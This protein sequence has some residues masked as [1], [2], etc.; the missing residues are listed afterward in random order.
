MD[1]ERAADTTAMPPEGSWWAYGL[2]PEER[3]R[4]PGPPTSRT[5]AGTPA[6]AGR[7]PRSRGAVDD[8]AALSADGGPK[9]VA[10]DGTAI[11]S[12]GGT[13]DGRAGH[14]DGA[15]D[16]RLGGARADGTAALSADGGPKPA[17]PDGPAPVAARLTDPLTESAADLAARTAR[18]D[19][20]AWT[21]RAVA[22]APEQEPAVPGEVEWETGF[23]LICAPFAEEAAERFARS[24]A[25]SGLP[26]DAAA[27]RAAFTE[28]LTGRLV[29]TAARCLVAELHTARE[30]GRLDGGSAH[31]RFASFVRQTARRRGLWELLTRYPVL[32]RLLAQT[33]RHALDAWTELLR[34][35]A[36]DREAIVRTLL[37]GTDPG[38]L[39]EVAVRGDVHRRGRAVAVLTFAD[40]GRI[41]YKPRSLAT[42]RHFN[43]VLEWLDARLPEAGLRTLRLLDRATHGWVEHVAAAPCRSTAHVDRFYRRLGTLMAVLHALDATDIHCENLIACA[44]QP[45]LVDLETLFHPSD[46]GAVGDDPAQRALSASVL[47]IALLPTL[48]FGRSGG[49]DVSALGGGHQG[50]LPLDAPH[51]AAPGTDRMHL[52]YRPAR[53]PGADNRPR[54]GEAEVDP[55]RFAEA[56]LD[57]FRAGYDTIT[58]HRAEF[59]APDG[60]VRAFVSDEARVVARPTRFYTTLLD[61]LTHPDV[62]AD[63]LDR[64]RAFDLLRTFPVR[65]DLDQRVVRHEVTDLWAG[66]VPLFTHRVGG[67]D[68]TAAGQVLPR[69]FAVPAVDRVLAK[70][71]AMG[72]VDRYDQEWIIRAAVA[73]GAGTGAHPC[74]ADGPTG[75]GRGGVGPSGPGTA[76][77]EQCLAAARHIADR[78]IAGGF[79]DERR[80]NWLGL[81]RAD[82]R[83]WAV[84]PLG[85]GFAH[86]YTG[87]AVF[88]AQLA[89]LGSVPRYADAARR[90]V[91]PVPRLLEELSGQPADL[92][93]VGCG[94][95][96]GLGG[97]AYALTHLA[98]LLRDDEVAAWVEPAVELAAEAAARTTALTVADGLAGGV[99]TMLAVHEHTG[100]PAAARCAALCAE[101]LSSLMSRPAGATSRLPAGFA[102]GLHGV[103]WALTR[104]A[105]A[106]GAPV[107]TG[108]VE[109]L[110]AQPATGSDH[111]WRGGLSGIGF[112]LA[113]IPHGAHRGTGPALDRAVSDAVRGG[114]LPDH[115]L[116]RGEL[117]RLELLTLAAGLGHDAALTHLAHRTGA[118]LADLTRGGPRCAVPAGTDSPDLMNGLSGIGHGL[119]RL[120]AAETVPSVLALR[121][122]RKR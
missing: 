20:A 85:A 8:T 78:V 89:E 64:D 99:A 59:T 116:G 17:V 66:D 77:P 22:T 87:V 26:A 120:A 53:F 90:A 11:L 27:L 45:V 80:I 101:R 32:A 29:G 35:L 5:D 115:S 98:A 37:G 10:P 33:S 73:A 108:A 16:G 6:P 52:V 56:L 51:W 86:G 79:R 39:R 109:A 102:D 46:T 105:D 49:W 94:A 92:A 58:S 36:A 112:A 50:D 24:V 41:V 23:G 95:F 65:G 91:T 114:P 7:H 84:M 113:D 12:A 15:A 100:L 97:L 48:V 72:T 55:A 61:E 57:G 54:L 111:S 110:S 13:A 4:Q 60:P 38:P 14:A 31:E 19:W 83:H 104:H 1:N 107:P 117:G 28:H 96:D 88:L 63:A 93:A 9:R 3:R 30:R 118:L 82:E 21:E 119:L 42:H 106:T 44:D 25:A 62:L 122:P 103:G 70:V 121:P 71:E 34:R 69:V 2:R 43:R 75:S 40:G 18:P 68:V 76:G 47:R 67:R 81:Q 74:G